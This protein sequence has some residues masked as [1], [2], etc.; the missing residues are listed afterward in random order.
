MESRNLS[1]HTMLIYLIH[2]TNYDNPAIHIVY[3]YMGKTKI[4]GDFTGLKRS[5]F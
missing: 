3:I 5:T 4:W 2:R 1:V